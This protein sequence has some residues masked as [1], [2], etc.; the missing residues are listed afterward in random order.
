MKS[1]GLVLHLLCPL[2]NNPSRSSVIVDRRYSSKL[3]L[4]SANGLLGQRIDLVSSKRCHGCPL[5]CVSF[6]ACDHSLSIGVALKKIPSAEP[7]VGQSFS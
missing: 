5:S 7:L 3:E 4:V 1:P 6:F 2:P